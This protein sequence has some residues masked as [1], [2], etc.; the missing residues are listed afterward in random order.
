MAKNVGF[1]GLGMMGGPMASHLADAG[2][3]LTVCD[4]RRESVA[5]LTAKGARAAASPAD[6]GSAAETVLLSL[7]TPA[8]VRD[9][10]LGASGV[11]A[12]TKVKT[13]VDL[14]TTGARMAREIASALGAKGIAAVD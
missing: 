7:P 14:S 3:A 9:V 6:V 1:I 10:A 4:V 13:L 12:G 11:I 8:V 5:A 2:Y